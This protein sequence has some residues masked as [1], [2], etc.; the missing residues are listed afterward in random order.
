MKA[1]DIHECDCCKQLFTIE[2]GT[3][4]TSTFDGSHIFICEQCF[5]KYFWIPPNQGYM[6]EAIKKQS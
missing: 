5:D 3:F 6:N 4:L 1:D 2:E